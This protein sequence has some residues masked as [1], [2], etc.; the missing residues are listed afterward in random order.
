MAKQN[1]QPIVFHFATQDQPSAPVSVISDDFRTIV[2]RGSPNDAFHPT[3]ALWFGLGIALGLVAMRPALRRVML[4]AA[5]P[6]G[7][8]AA[9]MLFRGP[10]AGHLAVIDPVLLRA[11]KRAINRAYESASM[12]EALEA[13]LAID[14]EIEGGGS[15]DKIAFMEVAR[16]EGLRAAIAWRDARFAK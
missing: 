15:P 4:L 9:W 10:L 12:A 14:L 16:R 3:T 11:T 5:V 7:I 8:V 1:A 6:A 2:N 13:A